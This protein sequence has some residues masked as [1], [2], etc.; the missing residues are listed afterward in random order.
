LNGI[1]KGLTTDLVR[2]VT[3]ITKE[4]GISIR[5][6]FMLG[7]P[8]ETEKTMTE[9]IRFAKSLDLDVAVF[10]ITTPF[11]GTELY[12]QA[13][14]TGELLTDVDYSHYLMFSSEDFPYVPR[15]LTRELLRAYQKK[16][17]L[18]F[19][20]RPSYLL[21]RL[22]DI[23]TLGDVRRYLTGLLAITELA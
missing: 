6:F 5:G 23:R 21:K 20:L 18:Q 16:A 19:Y 12:Q 17:Y 14:E 15:G 1:K 3:R 22:A 4:E 11:P 10:H 9:T 8:G 13:L 2:R 7:L